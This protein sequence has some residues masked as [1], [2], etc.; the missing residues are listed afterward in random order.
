MKNEI[1][2]SVKDDKELKLQVSLGGELQICLGYQCYTLSS[3]V[4]NIVGGLVFLT[5]YVDGNSGHTFLVEV[6]DDYIVGVSAFLNYWKPTKLEEV[7][8][9]RWQ[10]FL[11]YIGVI[12]SFMTDNFDLSVNPV[13]V[14]TEFDEDCGTCNEQVCIE[15]LVSVIDIDDEVCRIIGDLCMKLS[16]S[17]LEYEQKNDF[18]YGW[19]YQIRTIIRPKINWDI[20]IKNEL[21][22]I[23]NDC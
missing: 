17:L 20:Y 23:I 22:S 9:K 4:I 2:V 16:M 13:H 8:Q 7:K 19:H 15:L 12:T 21:K 10:S 14:V 18:K 5:T 6:Q 1:T 11:G 3:Q